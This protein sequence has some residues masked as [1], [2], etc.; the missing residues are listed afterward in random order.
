MKAYAIKSWGKKLANWLGETQK[1]SKGSQKSD[2]RAENTSKRAE[3]ASERAEKD[4]ERAEKIRAW[5]LNMIPEGVRQDARSNMVSVVAGI[6]MDGQ[7]TTEGLMH[8]TGL[9]DRGVRKTIAS[10]KTLGL[11]T[12]VGSDRVGHWELVGFK[13]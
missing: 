10:L 1:G 4:M 3:N 8:L 7:I 13:P 5:A 9:S 6:G 2:E 12:R 11:L